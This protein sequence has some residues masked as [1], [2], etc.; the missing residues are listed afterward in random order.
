MLGG[1]QAYQT[2]DLTAKPR[3]DGDNKDRTHSIIILADVD[4]DVAGFGFVDSV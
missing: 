2:C 1:N 4:F 3:E